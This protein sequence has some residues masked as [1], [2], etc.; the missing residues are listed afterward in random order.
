MADFKKRRDAQ[1][2]KLRK[3][4]REEIFSKKRNI[5]SNENKGSNDPHS[6]MEGGK[7]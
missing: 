3:T 2:E 1:T 7:K 5:L 6:E 4:N